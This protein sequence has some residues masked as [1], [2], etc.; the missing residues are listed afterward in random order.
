MGDKSHNTDPPKLLPSPPSA[1]RRFWTA[2]R[3]DLASLF[4]TTPN[5]RII[6]GLIVLGAFGIGGLSYIKPGIDYV[7]Q[8]AI[9]GRL[10]AVESKTNVLVSEIDAGI[11]IRR[12]NACGVGSNNG[13]VFLNRAF[14]PIAVEICSD[15]GRL[16]RVMYYDDTSRGI[17][18]QITLDLMMYEDGKIARFERTYYVDGKELETD[19][20][21]PHGEVLPGGN[22]DLPTGCPSKAEGFASVPMVIFPGGY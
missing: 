7:R 13:N 11:M 17:V 16:D 1:I 18:K 3:S 21:G 8:L 6:I 12:G 5:P 4:P 20:V 10:K 19:L 9:R 2:F 22:C 15:S 14:R